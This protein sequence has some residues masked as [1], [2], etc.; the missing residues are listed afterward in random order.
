MPQKAPL[1]TQD[2]QIIKHATN[3]GNNSA[4]IASAAKQISAD[5]IS[6]I[7]NPFVNAIPGID[8]NFRSY[9]EP[10][11]NALNAVMT[12]QYSDALL[13]LNKIINE[14]Y[15][16]RLVELKRDAQDKLIMIMS[17]SKTAEFTDDDFKP[18]LALA[19][20]ICSETY[21][22]YYSNDKSSC[23]SI[24][25]LN[26]L[27]TKDD[28]YENFLDD[29]KQLPKKANALMMMLASFE[30]GETNYQAESIKKLKHNI[31][32]IL[33]R[34]ILEEIR[35]DVPHSAYC[36]DSLLETYYDVFN[37]DIS[38]KRKGYGFAS[39][40]EK[41]NEA[42]ETF[43]KLNKFNTDTVDGKCADE[44][45]IAINE[46]TNTFDEAN[47]NLISPNNPVQKYVPVIA[48]LAAA[49]TQFEIK[50]ILNETASSVNSWKLK[51]NNRTTLS[52]GAMLG[53]QIS[54]EYIHNPYSAGEAFGIFAPVGVDKTWHSSN[55]RFATKW[56]PN[57]CGLFMSFLD[58]G[59]VATTR[60]AGKDD[61]KDKTENVKI[62]QVLSPGLY[63]HWNVKGMPMAFG[64]GASY[65]PLLRTMSVEG[66]TENKGGM[67]VM[68]LLT[69]D[70]PMYFIQ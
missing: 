52:V 16:N 9:M 57:T 55:C 23:G 27:L 14:Y 45:D 5:I 29:D 54:R 58:V 53:F 43:Q 30:S 8:R 31:T 59:A 28:F 49:H 2:S 42:R 50:N 68:M 34:S 35:K 48:S 37:E 6:I 3:D 61:V 64:F 32:I 39:I 18:D 11:L 1:E 25:N 60:I 44:M 21:K 66:Q 20:K 41:L 22:K 15:E 33:N 19:N 36:Y 38:K 47:I 65:V 13:D 40:S 10:S 69:M 67:R 51:Q 4:K 46:V 24:A 70:V 7:D 12:G 26:E 56:L 63:F 17:K 62:T